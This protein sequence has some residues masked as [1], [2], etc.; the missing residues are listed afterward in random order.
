MHSGV[1][2]LF[3]YIALKSQYATFGT[4]VPGW[5]NPYIQNHVMHPLQGALAVQDVE[6]AYE[7]PDA[8]FHI[9][10][11]EDGFDYYR[12]AT[13]T[14]KRLPAFWCLDWKN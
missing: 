2:A 5:D 7:L 6:L 1:A 4:A 14:K 9:R 3:A 10:T 13:S 12:Q 11:C 8:Y